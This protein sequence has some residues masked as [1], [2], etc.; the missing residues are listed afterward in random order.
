MEYHS[1][2]HSLNPTPGQPSFAVLCLCCA[3]LCSARPLARASKTSHATSRR[4]CFVSFELELDIDS[5]ETRRRKSPSPP[6][7][8]GSIGVRSSQADA[9]DTTKI[10]FTYPPSH[11][12][13]N[14][15]RLPI[16]PLAHPRPLVYELDFT[17]TWTAPC[18]RFTSGRKF[19]LVVFTSSEASV[20]LPLSIQAQSNRP[21]SIVHPPTAR[22]TPPTPK[23]NS[24]CRGR[25]VSTGKP[26]AK[27]PKVGT[28]GTNVAFGRST[29]TQSITGLA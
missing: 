13:S 12:N 21:I 24:T 26:T 29:S 5:S 2:A 16:N 14:P 27:H 6:A 23:C 19:I 8:A 11:S 22:G 10:A 18:N 9:Y 20:T 4:A 17:L 28:P 25:L 7:A 15:Y 1:T 3:A